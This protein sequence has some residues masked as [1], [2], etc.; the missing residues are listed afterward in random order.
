MTDGG[1]F[2]EDGAFRCLE[3]LYHWPR[4]VT[5]GFDDRDALI[6]DHFGISVVV[7]WDESGEEG[8]VNTERVFGH[9]PASSNLFLEVFGGGLG[10]CCELGRVVSTDHM[11]Q[12]SVDIQSLDLQHC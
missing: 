2:V 1:A 3:L 8:Q 10:E 12:Q 5:G 11:W 6:Y 9:S 4:T 7:W